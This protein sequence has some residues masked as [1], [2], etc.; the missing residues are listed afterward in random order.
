M[1]DDT[2][3]GEEL[4]RGLRERFL[5]FRSFPSFREVDD[6]ALVFLA[7]R[8][9]ERRFPAGAVL[10]VPGAPLDRFWIVREGTLEVWEHERRMAEIRRPRGAG[11]L[12]MVAEQHDGVVVRAPVDTAVLE[13][14]RADYMA[15]Y[16]RSP[17]F[18]RTTIRLLSA[19]LLELRDQLPAS[20]GTPPP[21]LG[22][23]PTRPRTLVERVR[24]IREEL[25]VFRSFDLD[26]V[27]T[28]VRRAEQR[29]VPPDTV[30]WRAGDP[31]TF[32]LRI[33]YGHVRCVAPSG[34]E[35]T[36]G[37]PFTLGGADQFAAL[38]RAYTATTVTE[39]W[40]DQSD[41]DAFL[42]LMELYPRSGLLLIRSLAEANLAGLRARA[43]RGTSLP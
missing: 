14:Q 6:S 33:D 25:S 42:S 41:R 38:P 32:N 11:Y 1:R 24:A 13:L 16:L 22:S 28:L 40:A 18:I 9:V 12:Q 35:V 39:V 20:P 27:Y 5:V 2:L 37:A 30:L 36:V 23:P 7:E 15:A 3:G 10:N 17:A 43:A 8:A 26:A 4:E 19:Q 29:R 21:P 31:A 34:A